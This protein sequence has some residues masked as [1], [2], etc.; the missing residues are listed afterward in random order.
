MSA[1]F[2]P[3]G[4]TTIPMFLRIALTAPG[5]GAEGAAVA[6]QLAP[7]P[8]RCTGGATPFCCVLRGA[9]CPRRRPVQDDCVVLSRCFSAAFMAC[10]NCGPGARAAGQA[11]AHS[12]PKSGASDTLR[13]SASKAPGTLPDFF[14][15]RP[16]QHEKARAIGKLL[17][18]LVQRQRLH[19]QV[20][21]GICVRAVCR[22]LR[23][24]SVE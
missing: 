12:G 11:A 15:I 17:L 14:A 10:A 7:S 6:R 21:F 18:C 13:C 9:R 4:C 16:C 5:H 19:F 2:A 8:G 23:L 20:I 1:G 22:C 3:A 24:G